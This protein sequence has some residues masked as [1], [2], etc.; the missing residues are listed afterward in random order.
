MHVNNNSFRGWLIIEAFEKRAPDSG[1]QTFLKCKKKEK[2]LENLLFAKKKVPAVGK[3]VKKAFY[4]QPSVQFTL[5]RSYNYCLHNSQNSQKREFLSSSSPF[6]QGFEPRAIF[7]SL[8]SGIGNKMSCGTLPSK[9]FPTFSWHY[10][11][12]KRKNEAFPPHTL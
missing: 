7:Y 12:Q 2:P 3:K 9:T 11:L 8:K 5:V 10:S 6:W 4:I 1:L